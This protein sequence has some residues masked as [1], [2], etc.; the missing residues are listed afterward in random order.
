[1]AVN[2][3]GVYRS[4]IQILG[5]GMDAKEFDRISTP[6]MENF[7]ANACSP[8]AFG[9]VLMPQR[10]SMPRPHDKSAKVAHIFVEHILPIREAG[11]YLS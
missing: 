11:F 8:L 10:L 2:Y 9:F 5:L 1:M 3:L 7:T 6:S 4:A